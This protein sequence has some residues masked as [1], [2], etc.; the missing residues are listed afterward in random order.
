MVPGPHSCGRAASGAQKWLRESGFPLN[1]SVAN[2]PG[3]DLF[4]VG[5]TAATIARRWLSSRPRRLHEIE[6]SA[7]DASA[8]RQA[9]STTPQNVR[10][11]RAAPLSRLSTFILEARLTQ[12][13]VNRFPMKSGFLVRF[14]CRRAS[15]DREFLSH[16]QRPSH[17]SSVSPHLVKKFGGRTPDLRCAPVISVPRNIRIDATRPPVREQTILYSMTRCSMTCSPILLPRPLAFK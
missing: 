5:A 6:P 10:G 13:P 1:A 7:T 2:A 3:G 12:G 4:R 9:W 17:D 14:G 11:P 15:T 8:F 16:S